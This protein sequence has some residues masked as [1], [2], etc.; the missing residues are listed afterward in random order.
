MMMLR[1]QIGRVQM[2]GALT[3]AVP[4]KL[5][6]EP[7]SSAITQ[8]MFGLRGITTMNLHQATGPQTDGQSVSPDRLARSLPDAITR[9]AR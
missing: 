3:P 2:L 5:N 4:E 6:G 7:R 9:P 1:V 8:T